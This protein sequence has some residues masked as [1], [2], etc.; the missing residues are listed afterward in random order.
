M[1]SR[2][3]FQDGILNELR[4]EKIE[5]TIYLVNGFQLQGIIRGFD[6]FTVIIE[7]DKR[8]QMIFKHAISTVVPEDPLEGIFPENDLEEE[9]SSGTE[10][11]N[12]E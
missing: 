6:N 10:H 11:K 7:T 1:S 3:N 12:N 4:K 2:N 9:K 8:L 5:A